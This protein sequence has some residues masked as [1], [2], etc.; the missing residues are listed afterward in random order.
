MKIIINNSLAI[1]KLHDLQLFYPLLSIKAEFFA[2]T[3]LIDR[4]KPDAAK[5]FNEM[6]N[7]GHIQALHYDA[8][9]LIEIRVFGKRFRNLSLFEATSL[10]LAHREKSG[11]MATHKMVRAAALS[12]GITVYGYDRIF[13][14]IYSQINFHPWEAFVKW[15]ELNERFVASTD[16]TDPCCVNMFC[17]E[18]CIKESLPQ[19]VNQVNHDVRTL[20]KH[21]ILL[22]YHQFSKSKVQL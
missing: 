22:K 3:D 14:E 2:S 1:T 21:R 5:A 6:M 12:L 9:E 19:K 20:L 18:T 4:L 13:D 17:E 8:E 16:R 7:L 15:K 11:L 10:Y